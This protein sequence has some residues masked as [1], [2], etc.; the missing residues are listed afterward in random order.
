M[1]MTLVKSPRRVRWRIL[2]DWGVRVGGVLLIAVVFLAFFGPLLS[3][4]SPFLTAGIPGAAS[5]GG[6]LLGLDFEGRDVL[7]RVLHGGS[8]T[9]VLATAATLVIYAAGISVGL[10]A[11]Y[12]KSLIDPLLMRG[13]D[14]LLSVPSLLVMLLFIT[15]LGSSKPVLVLAAAVV[16]FP[17][18]ARIVRSA[19][20]EVSTRGFVEAAIARGEK[21][22]AI[23]RREIL[24]NIIPPIVA[25][26]GLRFS[27]SIIL[28]AS[29]N[30]LGLGIK[31][32]T[33]DWG[34]MISENLVI[35]SSNPWA[36]ISPALMIGVLIIAVNLI[37]DGV[38]RQL[39][40]SG[41]GR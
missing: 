39:G 3:G 29:V 25:D 12:S 17:G 31:P 1:T 13:V 9:I 8:S 2:A 4:Q 15:G 34:V 10:L 19:T 5:G 40:T 18:A 28:I 21:T 38:V 36:V 24:P 41:S 32:P 37:G 23:L 20:L 33:P 35:L 16:L 11:G 22:F 7:A 30:F 14:V 26:M 27:W 6:H